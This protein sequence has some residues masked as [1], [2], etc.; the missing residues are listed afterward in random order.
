MSI[1]YIN[2]T[3]CSFQT[4]NFKVG[5]KTKPHYQLCKEAKW[6]MRQFNEYARCP[7]ERCEITTTTVRL[8]RLVSTSKTS[9][10]I[11]AGNMYYSH[12]FEASKCITMVHSLGSILVLG[13][14]SMSLNL[15]LH[16]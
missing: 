15:W 10:R 12:T 3:H 6:H 4:I 11:E 9:T 2:L 7:Y 5:I 1:F 16:L 13:K 14:P 8:V